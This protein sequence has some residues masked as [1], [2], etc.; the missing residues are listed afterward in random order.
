MCVASF[1]YILCA[2]MCLHL[3]HKLDNMKLRYTF[4][5]LN[6]CPTCSSTMTDTPCIGCFSITKNS[7]AYLPSSTA[8]LSDCVN[9]CMHTIPTTCMCCCTW[10][11]FNPVS[12]NSN[13]NCNDLYTTRATL[14]NFNIFHYCHLF[15]QLNC[16]PMWEAI[17]KNI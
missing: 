15:D 17:P 11:P 14:L 9:L 13:N 7:A 6:R 4:I 12:Q 10:K 5:Y 1:I 2:C 3:K 16:V 8:E